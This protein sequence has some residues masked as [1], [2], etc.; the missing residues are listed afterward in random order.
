MTQIRSIDLATAPVDAASITDR[1]DTIYTLA[2][3]GS[4][5]A[6]PNVGHRLSVG[7]ASGDAALVQTPERIDSVEWVEAEFTALLSGTQADR[8]AEFGFIDTNDLGAYIRVDDGVVKLVV[9]KSSSEEQVT[10]VSETIDLTRVHTWAVRINARR[11]A[12]FF[13]DGESLGAIQA[14]T[15]VLT[16]LAALRSGVRLLN[17]AAAVSTATLDVHRWSVNASELPAPKRIGN[18]AAANVL[19]IKDEGGFLYDLHAIVDTNSERYVMV[20]DKATAPIDTDVPV[21]RTYIAGGNKGISEHLEEGAW[22]QRFSKGI[23]VA[24]STTIDTLTLPGGA[25]GFFDAGF[26]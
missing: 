15:A 23:A 19:V 4:V 7:S 13:V 6:V 20:F 26:A 11:E 14:T 16:E 9:Q 18:A 25:E 21:L 12:Q 1:A 22:P 10:T 17:P 2:G 8:Q 3:G 24:V 5:A